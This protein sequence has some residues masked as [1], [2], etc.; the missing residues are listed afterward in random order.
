[1]RCLLASAA[2][3]ML[4]TAGTAGCSDP[5]LDCVKDLSTTCTPLYAPT[6]DNVLQDTLLPKCATGGGSCHTPEGHQAGLSFDKNDPDGAYHQMMSNSTV[7]VGRERVAPG[8][9]ACSVVV[10]RIETEIGRWHMPRGSTLADNEKCSIVQWIAQGA[11]R[12]PV[13]ATTP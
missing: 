11:L 1:M 9:P 10:E 2:L 12:N 8:D 7:H 5:P 6:F 4:I 13:D 3:A